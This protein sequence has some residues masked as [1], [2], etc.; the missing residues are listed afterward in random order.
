MGSL[1]Y[2]KQYCSGMEKG[3]RQKMLKEK[4]KSLLKDSHFR[5]ICMDVLQKHFDE[6]L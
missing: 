3:E 5:T 2:C 1:N 6:E 4:Y